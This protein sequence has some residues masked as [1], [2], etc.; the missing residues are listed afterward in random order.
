MIETVPRWSGLCRE[1][2]KRREH[3]TADVPKIV[4]AFCFPPHLL[5]W[6]ALQISNI[7]GKSSTAET[8]HKPSLFF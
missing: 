2:W 3:S 6:I 5:L 4:L 8:H 1:L 7:L